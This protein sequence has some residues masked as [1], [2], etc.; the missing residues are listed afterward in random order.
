MVSILNSADADYAILGMEETCN[1]DSARRIGNEYLFQILAEQNM[2][3]FNRYQ[4]KKILTTCPHC[5]HTLAHEYPQFGGIFQ[6]VHHTQL[7]QELIDSG[8][9]KLEKELGGKFTYHDS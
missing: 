6:V 7:L 8:K 2:E 5:Y 3:T 4:F 1:G 9:I